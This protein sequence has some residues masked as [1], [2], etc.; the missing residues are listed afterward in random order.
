M[1]ITTTRR[2]LIRVAGVSGGMGVL[3]AGISGVVTEALAQ[4]AVPQT[5]TGIEPLTIKRRGVGL[6]GLRS[7]PCFPGVH[8]VCSTANDQQDR[9]PHRYAGKRRAHLEY[10][11]PAWSIGISHR[12]RDALLQRPD[13]ERESSWPSALQ[14][15]RRI[16]NGLE[17]PHSV[18]GQPSPP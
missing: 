18:G 16:R 9:L 7:R 10:A 14:G 11:L 2:N 3:Q 8:A 5:R 13:P 6:R 1:A 15:W 12:P 4:Q 17:G